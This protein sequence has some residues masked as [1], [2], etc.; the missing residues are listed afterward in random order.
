MFREK[1]HESEGRNAL[2]HHHDGA[3]I[4]SPP[5]TRLFSPHCLSQRFQ[6]LQINIPCLP[7]VWP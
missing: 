4:F 5:Q 3:A 1:N 6:H 2:E 7:T